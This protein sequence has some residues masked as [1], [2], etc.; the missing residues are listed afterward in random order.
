MLPISF[1]AVSDSQLI[2]FNKFLKFEQFLKISIIIVK[3]TATAGCDKNDL[4]N[5]NN[6]NKIIIEI[7][8]IIILIIITIIIITIIIVIILIIVIK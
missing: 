8:I 6:N 2:F 7:I 3:L 1:S 4:Y 5:N